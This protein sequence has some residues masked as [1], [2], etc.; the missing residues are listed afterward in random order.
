MEILYAIGI[1]YA[2]NRMCVDNDVLD[3]HAC[4]RKS[5]DYH[6]VASSYLLSRSD[7][8]FL[9]GILAN[10]RISFAAEKSST[11]VE[12]SVWKERERKIAKCLC[13]WK[14]KRSCLLLRVP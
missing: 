14:K 3:L 11:F 10:G 6:F 1:I 7:G 2:D 9:R 5:F 8:F 12:C 4:I 13:S